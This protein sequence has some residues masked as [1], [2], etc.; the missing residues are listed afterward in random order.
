M[1]QAGMMVGTAL[2]L[3]PEQ[4]MGQE[5]TPRS[6]LYS[7]GCVLYELVTGRPPFVGDENVAIIGQHLNANP[8][9]PVLAPPRLPEAARGAHPAP[10]GEGPGKRPASAAEVA[11]AL[12]AISA[13]PHRTPSQP[14]PAAATA[15]AAPTPSTAASSSGARA[16]LRQLEAAFDA[17]VSGQGGLVMVVGEPG[18]GKTTLTEQLTTYAALRGGRT[19]VGHCY[20]EGS[21]SL[22]YLPFV[23]AMRSYV[24][25][26]EPGSSRSELGS[27]AADVARIVSEVR[28]RVQV[29]P[30]AALRRPRGGP[31]P[32][33]QRGDL[34]PAQRRGGAA[35]GAGAGRPARRRPRH[36]RPAA[37]SS[38]ASSP[39]ARLLR[40]RHL[41]RCRGGPRPSALRHA[42]RAAPRRPASAA[43]CCAA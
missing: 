32:A 15:A 2:Y 16:E 31:L 35:A 25:E 33:A 36:A 9:A 21:L 18:I 14:R 37:P 38:P 30:V 20:E 11:E 1:T 17:A 7:L 34:L 23:E 4:A 41:P 19:L 42:G 5:V 6:D 13:A 26:R 12:A 8:V 24:L 43:W 39:A 40:R 22:P 10:A 27:A 28:D 3:P 29:E